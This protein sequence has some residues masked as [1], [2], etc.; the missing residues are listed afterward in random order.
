M[1]T[2]EL[3]KNVE[4]L[5]FQ[6]NVFAALVV[7]VSLAVLIQS[8]FLFFKNERVIVVPPVVE[9]VFWVDSQTVS[10]TYLEQFGVF[11]GQLLLSKSTNSAEHQRTVLLRHSSPRFS[12]ELRKRLIQEESVLSK[13]K[14]SYVFLPHSAE[15]DM[16]NLEVTLKGE[17]SSYASGH[18]VSTEPEEYRIQFIFSGGRL[19]LNGV[20]LGGAS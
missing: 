9:K 15:V 5:C 20:K 6:R 12:S 8:C 13:Q 14:T 17:R 19:L 16:D 2:A 18:C 7:I 4:H 1:K 11:I 10:S 3:G